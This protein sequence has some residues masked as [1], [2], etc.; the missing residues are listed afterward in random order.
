MPPWTHLGPAG[1]LRCRARRLSQWAQGLPQ[2]AA[3]AAAAPRCSHRHATLCQRWGCRR[4][5]GSGPASLPVG[6][7]AWKRKTQEQGQVCC[8]R[9]VLRQGVSDATVKRN[10]RER[11]LSAGRIEPSRIV[12]HPPIGALSPGERGALCREPRLPRALPLCG[13][14]RVGRLLGACHVRGGCID[15][16]RGDN[17][18]G[19]SNCIHRVLGAC[20]RRHGR[21]NRIGWSRGQRGLFCEAAPSTR[22]GASR[23]LLLRDCRRR[24]FLGLGLPKG[25]TLQGL[26]L[27]SGRRC[28]RL[29]PACTRGARSAPLAC[30]Q[31][32]SHLFLCICAAL[33][34]AGKMGHRGI[35]V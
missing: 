12:G 26:L 10:G 9:G 11:R 3:A 8:G 1:S 31:T 24:L 14:H 35:G 18:I 33:A 2:W 32:G 28:T 5:R 13:S 25:G 30:S 22:R 17:H 34:T 19:R 16:G 29:A 6:W 23:G 15:Q 7:R 27:R 20:L 21:G 4:R